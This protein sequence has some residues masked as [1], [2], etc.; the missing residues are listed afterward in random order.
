MKNRAA[1]A[2]ALVLALAAAI[3]VAAASGGK[4]AKPGAGIP[5]GY[6]GLSSQFSFVAA[7]NKGLQQEAKK[8]GAKIVIE[9]R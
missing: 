2:A 4:Q 6:A 1:I 3:G 7:V 5:I 8:E 9:L